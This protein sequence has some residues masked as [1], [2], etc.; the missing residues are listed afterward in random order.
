MSEEQKEEQ[1]KEH[2]ASRRRFFLNLAVG[3]VIG[4]GGVLPGVSGGVMAVS[5]GVYRPMI[6][7]LAGF[8]KDVKKNFFYLLPVGLGAVIGFLLGA[9]AL[10]GV[11]DRWYSQVIWL[12][13]GLVAGG[14]PSFLKEANERGFKWR[15]LIATVAGAAV[16]SLLLLMK[17]GSGDVENL[18]SLNALQALASGAIVSVGTVFPGVS[19]SFVLMYL[20]WYKAMMDA[21]ARIDV[22]T[23]AL[24]GAGAAVC[25]VATVKSAR[26]L[27][28]KYHGYAYYGVLGFLI[29][30]AALIIPGVTLSW[31]LAVDLAL[32]AVGAA[33]AYLFGKL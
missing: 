4:L 11:M 6:E 32:A 13:L 14:L 9:V 28:E 21:F 29:V 22:L 25:F 18:D 26:W 31:M 16:A 3:A 15:Y 27:F 33:V 12:F 1:K 8:F 5:L 24:M 2:D 17:S 19:T 23:V 30:S 10:S 20:G 7:A